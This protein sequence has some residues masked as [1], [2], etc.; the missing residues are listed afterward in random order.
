MKRRKKAGAVVL[1]VMLALMPVRVL[2]GRGCG[3]GGDRGH[4]AGGGGDGGG[5]G[6][7]ALREKTR[8]RCCRWR[9]R[10]RS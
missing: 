10:R 8:T 3:G 9:P 7:G 1:A 5:D 6:A 4:G 2:G